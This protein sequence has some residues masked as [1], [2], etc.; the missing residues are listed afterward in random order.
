MKIELQESNK[1]IHTI[2]NRDE[3]NKKAGILA[4]F[5]YI[6]RLPNI[7]ETVASKHS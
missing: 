3:T 2:V 4:L 5:P 7:I 6:L 1:K